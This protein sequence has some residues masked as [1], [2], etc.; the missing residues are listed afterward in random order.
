MPPALYDQD[1]DMDL[2]V[3]IWTYH[4]SPHWRYAWYVL[5]LESADDD[6]EVLRQDDGRPKAWDPAIVDWGLSVTR[7]GAR[8]RAH[9]VARRYRRRGS[10]ALVVREG[11]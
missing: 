3:E 6:G 9:R 11:G 5:D 7:R 2:S 8:R 10:P 1:D 4:N